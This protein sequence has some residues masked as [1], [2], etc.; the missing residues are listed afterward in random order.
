[1]SADETV[2]PP[3]I[4]GLRYKALLGSGGFAHV[5]RYEQ[6]ALGR[7]VAVKVIHGFDDAA[8]RHFASEAS[9]MAR[10]SSHPHVVPVYQVG[11]SDDARPYLVMQLCPG[12]NLADRMRARPLPVAEALQIGIQVAG[13]VE[14]AHRLGILHRDIKPANI[15]FSE[16][17]R[18][19]LADFGISQSL[20][21]TAQ[22]LPAFS[23]AWA[24][25]EQAIGQGFAPSADVYSMCA[26]L[27]AAL[28][29]KAPMG[30]SRPELT[31]QA[32]GR[33]DVPPALE[34][35]LRRGLAER[36]DQRP[37][38][39][40]EL[41]RSLQQ[42]QAHLGLAVTPIELWDG[43]D[44]Q[45]TRVKDPDDRTHLVTLVEPGP[46]VTARATT[47]APT[48]A[49]A[50]I[51][52]DATPREAHSPA[53]T[54]PAEADQFHVA[55]TPVPQPPAVQN[56]AAQNRAAPAPW[57]P[58]AAYPVQPGYLSPARPR[59][60]RP[61]RTW[62]WLALLLLALLVLASLR[63]LPHLG[64]GSTPTPTPSV[65]G[66]PPVSSTTSGPSV[67]P[68][69]A[70]PTTTTPV[71]SQQSASGASKEPELGGGGWGG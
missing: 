61:R 47:G 28:T 25:P 64:G 41:G 6:T 42:V 46:E 15:L 66:T 36:A 3:L 69:T 65:S 52:A 57:P 50:S 58:A 55:D 67:T 4:P 14:T 40:L 70:P 59:E 7:D 37:S 43:E 24:P 71:P 11:Q 32:L 45:T 21:A 44:R 20:E 54:G 10:L 68:T 33:S 8:R 19:L 63:F 62:L 39:A 60:A 29:G 31:A 18:P 49:A 5:Y 30:P 22:P 35:L 16:Y 1:M 53:P 48:V 51:P 23:P 2:G 26:T 12:P 17:G 9:L 56:P 13:A 34:D 27:W 38:S